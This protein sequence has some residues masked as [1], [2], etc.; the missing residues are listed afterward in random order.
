[1]ENFAKKELAGVKMSEYSLKRFINRTLKLSPAVQK[2]RLMRELPSY[3]SQVVIGLLLSDGGVERPTQTGGARLSVKLG[4]STLP[5][6]PHFNHLLTPLPDSA[7]LHLEVKDK[8]TGKTYTTVR[9]KTTMLPLF[10]YYH[11]LFYH[12]DEKTQRYVK[13]VPLNID[14]LMTPVVLAHLIMGDGNLKKALAA[15]VALGCCAGDNI[16]RIYTNSFTRPDVERLASAITSKLGIETKAVHDRNDQYMLTINRMQLDR[17]RE[18]IGPHMH[19][20]MYY[21]LGLDSCDKSFDYDNI[22]DESKFE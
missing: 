17:V 7:I 9:F 19:P 3:L 14:S 10:I 21:K 8:I 1:M 6:I 15:P 4:I 12:T 18:L 5:T 2:Y 11:E 13:R 16:I 20:S 22:T